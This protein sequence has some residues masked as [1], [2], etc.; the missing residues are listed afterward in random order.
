[1]ALFPAYLIPPYP[2]GNAM[3]THW[4][5]CLT[6]LVAA[7]IVTLTGASLSSAGASTT[8]AAPATICPHG[9]HWDNVLHMCI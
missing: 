6:S 4:L 3:R 1:M 7:A 5:R 9:T 2:K 8:A